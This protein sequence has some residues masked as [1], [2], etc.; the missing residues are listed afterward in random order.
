MLRTVQLRE[1]GGS[2]ELEAPVESAYAHTLS[3]RLT[4]E[5][6]RRLRRFVL[7]Q[8]DRTGRR[9]THQA[10]LERALSE[11]LDKSAKSRSLQLV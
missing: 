3:M 8:E 9:F 10:L 1:S 2:A 5:Q 7:Q 11:Y 4:A 6:Y